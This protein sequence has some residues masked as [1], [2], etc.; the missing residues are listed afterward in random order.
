MHI[1]ANG[2]GPTSWG[3]WCLL[4]PFRERFQIPAEKHDLSYCLGTTEIDK[5]EADE[6][7][8]YGCAEAS[9]NNPFAM[10]MAITYYLMVF[11]F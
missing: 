8:L 3:K 10:V 2:L 5:E 4:L 9:G 6:A 7:F 11:Y 1:Y